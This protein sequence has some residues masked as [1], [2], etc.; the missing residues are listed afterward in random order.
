MPAPNEETIEGVRVLLCSGI[1]AGMED[2][3][4]LVGA[5]LEDMVALVMEAP[6]R[7]EEFASAVRQH[8]INAG[9]A[10]TRV[11]RLTLGRYEREA[12]VRRQR[13]R[14]QQRTVI[15]AAARFTEAA[16]AEGGRR[17]RRSYAS[18]EA[19]AVA[20]ELTP[21]QRIDSDS[22]FLIA[23]GH[24]LSRRRGRIWY[25]SHTFKHMTN[26]HGDFDETVK[27]PH[28][29][30]DAFERRVYT[31]LL[32]IDPRLSKLGEQA[33]RSAI[34]TVAEMDQRNEVQDWVDAL[35]WDGVPRLA[36]LFHRAYGTPNDEYHTAIGQNWFR[37]MMARMRDPGAKVDTMPVLMGPQGIHKSQ[38][39]EVIGGRW[40]AAAV[41]S[42]GQ[43][44]FLQELQGALV[45]EIPE[46]H[47]FMSSRIGASHIK[48]VLSSRAD[49][50]RPAWE[51]N[52]TEFKRTAVVVGT[53]NDRGWHNDDTGGRRFWPVHCLGTIDLEWLKENR[54][55]LFAEAKHEVAQGATWWEVP[56]EEQERRVEDERSVDPY[57]EIIAARMDRESIYSG[58]MEE[59]ITAWDGTVSEHTVWGNVLTVNRIGISW[60]KMTPEMVGRNAK[61]IAGA[62]RRLGFEPKMGRLP[63]HPKV[64]RYWLPPSVT[65]ASEE[66]VS[67]TNSGVDA[68][69]GNEIDDD[70]PF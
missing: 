56:V 18:I 26:W 5:H 16:R 8:A 44:K 52:V 12:A 65:N 10:R 39:L 22:P 17:G 61:R 31:W 54:D 20:G 7:A 30:S 34:Q 42:I 60:M 38:S 45:F 69:I 35:E 58:G 37:S 32:Q 21:E 14:E 67:V 53:T 13:E 43:E 27:D 33:T 29:I 4:T 46:L 11:N 40:Y 25:D 15:Q 51:R 3:F 68:C 64:L 57:E 23:T 19:N 63:G 66:G 1:D 9:W 55:Q 59:E 6:A 24:L 49:R 47:S 48:A 2:P 36:T 62:L 50:F 70:I 41:S 28:R